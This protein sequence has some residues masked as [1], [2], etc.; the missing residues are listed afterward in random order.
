MDWLATNTNTIGA[1]GG[2]IATILGAWS[3]YTK[4]K[5]AIKHAIIDAVDDRFGTK[6]DMKRIEDQLESLSFAVQAMT[7]QTTRI[8]DQLEGKQ[9]AK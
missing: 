3:L 9:R 5:K 2:L 7:Y 8:L 6:Q 4:T 1:L